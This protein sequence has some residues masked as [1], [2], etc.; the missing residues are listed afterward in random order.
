MT[1]TTS[2]PLSITKW[3]PQATC[4]EHRHRGAAM[5]DTVHVRETL[6][7]HEGFAADSGLE[8]L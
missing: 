8:R 5:T 2:I 7:R 6:L 1:D 4:L 3:P